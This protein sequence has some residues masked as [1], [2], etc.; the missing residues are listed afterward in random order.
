MPIQASYVKLYTLQ[1]V[2]KNDLLSDNNLLSTTLNST[3]GTYLPP[4]IEKSYNNFYEFIM[5]NGEKKILILE[6]IINSSIINQVTGNN[7]SL[8]KKVYISNNCTSIESS[9]FNGCT[10]LEYISYTNVENNASVSLTNIRD[11]AFQNCANLD[12]CRL[13]NITNPII[14]I[15][16]DAFN[17][18]SK[19]FEVRLENTQITTIGANAFFGCSKLVSIIFPNS[20]TTIGSNAFNG[21]SLTNIYFN[22]SLPSSIGSTIFGSGGTPLNAVCYYYNNFIDGSSYISLKNLFP[23][24]NQIVFVERNNNSIENRETFYSIVN[25]GVNTTIVNKATEIL[26]SLLIRRIGSTFYN[27]DIAYDSALSGTNTLGYASWGNGQIRLN[28]DNDTGSNVNMNGISLNLNSVVLVH[29]I[30]HIFGFG[31]G[32]LWTNFRSYNTALDYHFTGINAIYQYNKLLA[33]NGYEKKLDYLTIE[34]SG[35][36]G[37]MG[38]HTEEG[39]FFNTVTQGNGSSQT[40]Q[41]AQIR[42]DNKGNL[43]PSV[44]NDIMSGYLGNN[45]YFTKQC[46]GVLQDLEFSV[47]YNSTW[48]YGNSVS[49]YPSITFDNINIRSNFDFTN[50]ESN[51]ASNNISIFKQ[52][53]ANNYHFKCD[54]CSTDSSNNSVIKGF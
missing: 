25:N 43:Y 7:K 33:E 49:F 36:Y 27:I 8:L 9:C 38:A 15:G 45:N 39:Y 53:I 16:N 29:E 30:L 20:V 52:Q 18:C 31:S 44:Q 26:D 35:D 40:Y 42:G 21:T 14:S 32:T 50:V 28:P 37:T 19:L 41:N 24:S 22:G 47:N 3:S 11:N 46:C 23:N 54:C 17:G 48:Y 51:D 1:D 34:D 4:I 5:T 10:N 12:E 13:F 2:S 6:D